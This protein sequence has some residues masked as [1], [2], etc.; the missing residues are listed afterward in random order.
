MSLAGRVAPEQEAYGAVVI[1][2][3]AV[4]RLPDLI[5]RVTRNEALVLGPARAPGF[6]S[7]TMRD[8][9]DRR[10]DEDTH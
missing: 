3:A 10:R 4:T 6:S 8:I 7:A 1:P 2:H 5:E 9:L